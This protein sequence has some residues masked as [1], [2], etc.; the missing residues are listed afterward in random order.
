MTTFPDLSEAA[1]QGAAPAPAANLP[2]PPLWLQAGTYPAQLDR[3]LIDAL[4]SVPGILTAGDLLVSPRAAGANMS[5]DV[6]AGRAVVTGSDAPNQG[7]YL[8]RSLAAVNLVVG[9]AP[10]AGTSRIDRVVLHVYDSAIVGGTADVAAL[11][12]VAGT[13]A[14][15]PVAPAIPPSSILLAE[16]TI[17]AGLASI[18]APNIADRRAG[19]SALAYPRGIIASGPLVANAANNSVIPLNTVIAG[20]PGWLAANTITI[21]PGAGGLYA[22]AIDMSLG[23]LASMNAEIR[24]GA[25]AS[26]GMSLVVQPGAGV[27]TNRANGYWLRQCADGATFRAF[28]VQNA[29]PQSLQVTRFSLVRVGD[30]L[31]TS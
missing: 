14:A 30:A 19:G 28:W 29:N 12:I 1:G 31:A 21:P 20:A 24:D 15:S 27:L 6:A 26:L 23:T 11:E 7:K 18:T 22:I 17:P 8:A 13:A 25:N 16:L 4:W 2:D 3:A 9:A 5:V 10:G